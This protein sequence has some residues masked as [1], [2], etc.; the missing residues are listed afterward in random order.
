MISKISTMKNL[1]A[2]ISYPESPEH[3]RKFTDH[4]TKRQLV[5]HGH[6]SNRQI[7]ISALFRGM[8]GIF[9]AITEFLC[10][11]SKISR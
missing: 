8:F 11:Y 1:P 7:K 5:A 10:V 4:K 6:H 3:K 9:H 2:I